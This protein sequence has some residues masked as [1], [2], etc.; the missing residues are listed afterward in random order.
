MHASIVVACVTDVVLHAKVGIGLGR[1]LAT[2]YVTYI[3]TTSHETPHTKAGDWVG[4]V[5]RICNNLL[6]FMRV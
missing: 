2:T 3:Y 1:I 4:C 5:G 6:V